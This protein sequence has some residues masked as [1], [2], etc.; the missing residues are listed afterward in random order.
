MQNSA[1][2]EVSE[3]SERRPR[4]AQCACVNSNDITGSNPA[5]EGEDLTLEGLLEV[6]VRLSSQGAD[7]FHLD[8]SMQGLEDWL[9]ACRMWKTKNVR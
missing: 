6:R 2:G 4:G 9:A 7:A 5:R 1:K 8:P 3:M